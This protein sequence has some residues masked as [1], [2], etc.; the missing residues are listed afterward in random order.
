[1]ASQFRGKFPHPTVRKGDPNDPKWA[2]FRILPF[3]YADHLTGSKLQLGEEDR[4]PHLIGI[5]GEV[6]TPFG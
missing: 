5:F 6:K 3:P 1:M 2:Q 4:I